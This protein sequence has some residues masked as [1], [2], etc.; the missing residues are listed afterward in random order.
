MRL[1]NTD[2]FTFGLFR[3]AG[4]KLVKWPKCSKAPFAA[5]RHTL[6]GTQSTEPERMRPSPA[7]GATRRGSSYCDNQRTRSGER[8]LNTRPPNRKL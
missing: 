2:V 5:Y 8:K 7:K 3:Q 4:W 6:H 1:I